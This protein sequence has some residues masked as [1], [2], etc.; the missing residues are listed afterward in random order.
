MPLKSKRPV[1]QASNARMR[2]VAEMRI[3]KQMM[4]KGIL[5]ELAKIIGP[6]VLKEGV[7]IGSA[8]VQKHI[9]KKSKRSKGSS[10]GRKGKGLRP[11]G[12]RAPARRRVAP[13]PRPAPRPRVGAGRHKKKKGGRKKY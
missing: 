12:A 9:A 4:G 10:S 7:K 2:K 5:G 3:K 13:M 8:L 6:L 1:A 11:A